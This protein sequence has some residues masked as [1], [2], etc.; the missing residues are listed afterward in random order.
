MSLHFTLT[1]ERCGT[2]IHIKTLLQTGS[3][4]SFDLNLFLEEKLSSIY[5][6]RRC[7]VMLNKDEED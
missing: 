3:V 4:K 5:I 1:N 2:L 7:I 6:M